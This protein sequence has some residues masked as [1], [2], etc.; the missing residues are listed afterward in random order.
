MEISISQSFPW[1][2]ILILIFIPILLQSAQIGQEGRIQV[3]VEE[4][5]GPR[6]VED[7]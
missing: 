6:Q 7:P 3:Y 1:F 5:R 2:N 4:L